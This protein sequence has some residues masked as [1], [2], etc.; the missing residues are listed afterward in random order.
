MGRK[1]SCISSSRNEV[2]SLFSKANR[3]PLK[4]IS[5]REEKSVNVEKNISYS[6]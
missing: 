3:T 2:I 1:D 5:E 6:G 4:H